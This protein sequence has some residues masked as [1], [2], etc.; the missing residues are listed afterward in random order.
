MMP[1][2]GIALFVR[3]DRRPHPDLLRDDGKRKQATLSGSPAL[4]EISLV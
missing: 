1:V 2:S 3:N 4:N